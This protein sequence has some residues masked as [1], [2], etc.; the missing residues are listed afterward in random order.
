M[1]RGVDCA[2]HLPRYRD[3]DDLTMFIHGNPGVLLVYAIRLLQLLA[4]T[5]HHLPGRLGVFLVVS[6]VIL[7]ILNPHLGIFDAWQ[8]ISGN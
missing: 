3:L 5:H 7:L 1:I 8:V 6:L 4:K 2:A